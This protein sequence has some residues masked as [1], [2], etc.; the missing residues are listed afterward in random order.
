[1]LSHC[2]SAVKPDNAGD[3][4]SISGSGKSPGEGN[5]NPFQYSCLEKAHGQRSLAGYSLW[6]H[7]RVGCDLATKQQYSLYDYATFCYP[8][9]SKWHLG[10]CLVLLTQYMTQLFELNLICSGERNHALMFHSPFLD[11]YLLPMELCTLSKNKFTVSHIA[12]F[13]LTF[14]LCI[15]H[16]FYFP[17]SDA[18][19][20][21][22]WMTL[23]WLPLPGLASS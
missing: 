8:P 14:P 4:G 2:G 17:Y 11:I 6:G 1:M 5:G 10:V 16:V 15:N 18:L 21:V 19:L 7:K 13:I 3:V 12:L 9:I 23:E 20:F 22:A